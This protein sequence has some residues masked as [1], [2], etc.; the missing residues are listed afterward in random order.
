[1]TIAD[2][3]NGTTLFPR[4]PRTPMP[5]NLHTVKDTLVGAVMVRGGNTVKT[6][7][8]YG[9]RVCSHPDGPYHNCDYVSARNRLVPVAYAAA[10]AESRSAQVPDAACVRLFFAKMTEMWKARQ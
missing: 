4:R 9:N 1:M 3:K 10:Y 6:Q 2:F 7:F 8:D 5:G